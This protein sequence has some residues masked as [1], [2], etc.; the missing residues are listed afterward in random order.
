MISTDQI[1]EDLLSKAGW[2]PKNYQHHLAGILQLLIEILAKATFK[3]GQ[4]LLIRSP[5]S[6]LM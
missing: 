2:F 3:K 6:W 1:S 5:P 4:Y